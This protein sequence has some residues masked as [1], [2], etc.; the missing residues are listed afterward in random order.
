MIPESFPFLKTLEW[1][2]MEWNGGNGGKNKMKLRPF[3]LE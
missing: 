2:G 3:K 1:N